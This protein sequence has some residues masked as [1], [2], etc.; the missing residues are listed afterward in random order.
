MQHMINTKLIF[1]SLLQDYS[2]LVHPI[3]KKITQ[4]TRE[5]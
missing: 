1:W 4:H 3:V 5:T 2:S